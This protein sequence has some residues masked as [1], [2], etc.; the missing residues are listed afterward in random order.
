[1]E[2]PEVESPP[3]QGRQRKTDDTVPYSLPEWPSAGQWAK[4]VGGKHK[5]E[6]CVVTKVNSTKHTVLLGDG[7]LVSVLEKHLLPLSSCD[8]GTPPTG[9]QGPS[10]PLASARRVLFRQASLAQ[11]AS[12]GANSPTS[13]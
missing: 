12:A 7:G 5:G 2:T 9:A 8:T 11:S 10:P 4:V 13:P 1:M 3:T 6:S